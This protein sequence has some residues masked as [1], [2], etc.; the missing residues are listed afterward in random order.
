M[1]RCLRG[2]LV[3]TV[4]P[5]VVTLT[6]GCA[7]TSPVVP[8]A[9]IEVPTVTDTFEGTITI[10][11]AATHPFIIGT[12]S[13]V[14]VTLEVVAPAQAPPEG[15]F[16]ILG[17]SLGTWNTTTESCQIIIAKDDAIQGSIILGSAQTSGAFCVRV[18]DAGRLTS[19]SAYLVRVTH[20]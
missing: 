19:P 3:L 8:D 12:P 6:A 18:Y 17:L 2:A 4:L 1:F 11:G 5:L 16:T 7:N 15:T 9:P 14:S 13:T 20:Q 10:N